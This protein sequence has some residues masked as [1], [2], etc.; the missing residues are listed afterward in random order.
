MVGGGLFDY[1]VTP[2]PS[3]WNSEHLEKKNLQ[4]STFEKFSGGWV[5]GGLFD[6]SVTPGP[7]FYKSDNEL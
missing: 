7:S 3:L 5:G 6:Y 4:V 1:S 2:G